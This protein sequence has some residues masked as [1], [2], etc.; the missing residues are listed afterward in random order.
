M[1]SNFK[2]GAT[3]LGDGRCSFCVWAPFAGKVEVLF[4]A[5]GDRLEPLENGTH[6]Y[7]YS[8]L[9][10]IKP[11]DLYF[12][13]LDGKKKRPDPASKYQP[14][15]VHGPS[16]VVDL[17]NFMWSDQTWFGPAL[18][19]LI[20]Y[21]LHTGTFTSGGTFDDI[22]PHL[23]RLREL[24]VTAIELM[25]AAQFPGNRN[26]GY[27]GVFP[28]AAQNSYG[29]PE[30]LRRLV[31]NC[32]SRGMAV[33][34]DVVYNHLGPEGNY[35]GDFGPYV[36]DR[37]R[38]PWGSAM[39][40]DGPESDEV[41][42]FFIENAIFWLTEFHLDGLRLDAVHAITD[43]TARPFLAELSFAVHWQ[44]EQINRRLYLIAESDLNDPRI[45]QPRIIGGYGFNG[46]WNDDFHHALHSLLT[47]E[48][49]GYYQD[50]GTLGHLSHAFR[51]G[52]VYTGQ[53]SAYRRRRHGC[54]PPLQNGDLQYVVFAQNHDQIGNRADGTRLTAIV[55]FAE[56]K[57][58]AGVAI[59]SPFTPL[60]FMGEEYG[61]ISPFKYF[62]SYSDPELIEAVRKG[63]R[64]EFAAFKWKKEA[65]DP[66]DEA[67]FLC[68]K[69]KYELLR[70][71][72]HRILF[73]Y[74]RELIRLR[75]K[76]PA[77]KELS[78]ENMEVI[79]YEKE[80]VLLIL[81]WD[82]SQEICII[83]SFF[84]NEINISLPVPAGNWR[85]LLD[86]SEERW[87]GEGGKLPSQLI[88]SGKIQL[89]I[90]PKSCFLFER[91]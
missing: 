70:Q 16:Q 4:P 46:Q 71:K 34:L 59:L 86:S 2:L 26:W 10:N 9:R 57:L 87:L 84:H 30:A 17:R 42:R 58:A 63:R 24:G 43:K 61:E 76:L 60:L 73:E 27:D 80:K 8:A 88:S 79:D 45:T 1:A 29:G 72:S 49:S 68:S 65:Y 44:A 83:Y 18:Q 39:N 47:G 75:R 64:E 21:E 7:F 91:I 78:Q 89:D 14:Q 6:G 77:L 35:L 12:Y 36:T 53:Y 3:Y 33:F 31:D 90:N 48:Q 54:K 74:Y 5:S 19:D 15:G 50:F 51:K 82:G 67:A 28:F 56:L 20:F 62:T 81:R 11:G 32:H 38:T 40:F 37:Y 85:K 41:R 69:L 22:V 23:D 66:Q 55:S 52:Y 25:P 13:L